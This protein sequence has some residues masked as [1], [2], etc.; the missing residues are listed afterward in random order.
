MRRSAARRPAIPYAWI[1]RA[2]G[3]G[4]AAARMC[5]GPSNSTC[6][7]EG[8]ENVFEVGISCH[9]LAR[10]RQPRISGWR[11]V[12]AGTLQ[13]IQDCSCLDF[14]RPP[15]LLLR[16]ALLPPP[17]LLRLPGGERGAG[18][19]SESLRAPNGIE[20][21]REPVPISSSSPTVPSHPISSSHG[22]SSAAGSLH[23]SRN[24]LLRATSERQSCAKESCL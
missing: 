24:E 13:P 15:L 7:G 3:G 18:G 23:T 14:P 12:S 8:G 17:A 21:M 4:R 19:A 11:G 5:N 1:G 6:A 9:E 2:G 16:L 10:T 22:D 20:R